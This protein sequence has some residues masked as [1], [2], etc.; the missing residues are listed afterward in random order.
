MNGRELKTEGKYEL[1]TTPDGKEVINFDNMAYYSFSEEKDEEFISS[2]EPDPD[3]YSSK[4][5]G[6]YYF[7]GAEKEED[8]RRTIYLEDGPEFR[9]IDLP[10]GLPT[11][12]NEPNKKI[13]RSKDRIRKED[14]LKKLNN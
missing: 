14:V 7:T 12:R 9:K 10:E 6:G 8:P 1:F 13:V 11:K 3:K 2:T 4:A 5:T